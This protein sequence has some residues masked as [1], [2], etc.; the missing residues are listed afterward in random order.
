M[1]LTVT[2]ARVRLPLAAALLLLAPVSAEYVTGYD[3]STGDPLALVAG[4][5]IFAPLY[6]AP[7][8]L[9][10]EAARRRGVGWPGMLAL[11]AA[12][13]IVQAGMIDQ[14]LFSDSYRDIEGWSGT[15]LSTLVGPLGFSAYYAM[16]FIAGHVIWSY[17][18]PIALVESLRPEAAG[19]PWLRVPGLVVAVALYAGAAALIL[20][21]HL[22]TERDHASAAEL[23]GSAVAVALLV[24]YAFTLGRRR[25]RPRDVR[26]PRPLVVLVVSLVAALVFNVVPETWAGFACGLAVLAAAAALVSILARSPRWGD[27]HVAALAAGALLG[28]CVVGFLVVPLGDVSLMA[29]YGHNLVFFAGAAL[30]AY[31]AVARP[32]GAVERDAPLD[33]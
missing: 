10:R 26:V 18:V 14:S 12:F 3:T 21:E 25:P 33:R 6:G 28:R 4:L 32:L 7:A 1:H 27:R 24:V 23:A 29:K 30:L 8:L 20:S 19:R 15:Y 2:P 17:C 22:R 9:I 31:H 13:G 5:V 11:A 16:S